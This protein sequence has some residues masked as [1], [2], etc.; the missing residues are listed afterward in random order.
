MRKFLVNIWP[1][2]LLLGWMGAESLPN[3]REIFH[4]LQSK[5]G[6]RTPTQFLARVDSPL[7]KSQLKRIPRDRI[8]FG[9]KPYVIFVFKKGVGFR[10]LIRHVDE[11]HQAM[12][13]LYEDILYR[14]GL[15][16]TI[17][18]KN[19]YAKFIGDYRLYWLR[20]TKAYPR[21]LKIVEKDALP[22]DHGI[23]SCDSNWIV[24]YSEYYEEEKKVAAVDIRY[25][26]INQ[27]ELPKTL[28][29]QL[30]EEKKRR[31]SLHL[32]DFDFSPQA[33]KE[34]FR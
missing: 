16:A 34:Y 1:G 6:E 28:N 7:I 24:Q 13:S 25:Q 5:W 20:G 33:V 10:I 3:P 22:G 15:F 4:N 29:V 11:Y 2:I 21:R 30:F 18:E 27:Y 32:S 12:F 23:F 19:T 31:F 17:G 9:E 14:A 26:Q 8:E